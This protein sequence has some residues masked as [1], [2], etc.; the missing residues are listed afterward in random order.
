MSTPSAAPLV[1]AG[2][3]PLVALGWLPKRGASTAFV[4]AAGCRIEAADG[5][6]FL[7]LHNGAGTVLLGHAHP[8]VTEA[9]LRAVRAGLAGVASAQEA[10]V[11]E[12]LL[13]L[14][15]QGQRLRFLKTGSEVASLAVRLARAVTGRPRVIACG[16]HGWHDWAVSGRPGGEGVPPAVAAL[17]RRVAHGD[18]EGLAAALAE[19]PG[20]VAA[21]VAE[22]L[23]LEPAPGNWPAALRNAAD[24]HGAVL[25]FDETA[26]FLRI[27]RSGVQG[28]CGVRPDLTLIGKGLANG[29]PLAALTGEARLMSLLDGR[30]AALS[31]A[32]Q[33]G[34]ALAAAGAVL[35]VLATQDVP[36]ALARAGE[37]LRIG[38]ARAVAAA[39]LNGTISLA[40]HSS[41]MA[42]VTEGEARAPPRLL[43]ALFVQALLDRG[44]YAPAGFVPSLAFDDDAPLR[45]AGDAL[46]A[47]CRDVAAALELPHPVTA[48]HGELPQAVFRLR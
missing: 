10:A 37:A 20:G 3:P 1:L 6:S 16:Y 2:S 28:A 47:A 31:T 4:A 39:G 15:P 5:R 33:E 42:L 9:V 34:V 29:L 26:T 44:L 22:P 48:L 45:E 36:A 46:T 11:A 38:L 30:V 18:I 35:D 25:V 21:I 7:D 13:A 12:R 23:V 19:A 27:G 8:A 14:L 41:R 40:G 32:A 43:R 17:T 24:R